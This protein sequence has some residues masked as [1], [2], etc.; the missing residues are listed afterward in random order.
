MQTSSNVMGVL[1]QGVIYDAIVVT[2]G[3]TTDTYVYKTGG[4]SGTTV[5]TVVV[6]F[7]TSA[8]DILS[9]IVRT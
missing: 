6:T 1:L 5:A 2:T 9:T 3:S 7:T 4:T 8:K